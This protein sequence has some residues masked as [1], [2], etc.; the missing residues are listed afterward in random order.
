M[1]IV[2]C[3]EIH[4]AGF[5]KTLEES[6]IINTFER[7]RTRKHTVIFVDND[8]QI[9]SMVQRRLRS[10]L[11]VNRGLFFFFGALELHDTGG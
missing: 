7:L 3:V 10:F 2:F 11:R 5:P 8:R 6:G 9:C 1:L 4:F